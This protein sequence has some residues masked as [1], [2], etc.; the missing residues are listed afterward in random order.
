MHCISLTV[1]HIFLPRFGCCSDNETEAE[2]PDGLG[3]CK[4][5]E[6]GCCEDGETE[7][8]GPDG[9]GCPVEEEEMEDGEEDKDGGKL[10]YC[11]W[12][13]PN[14]FFLNYYSYNNYTMIITE[15]FFLSIFEI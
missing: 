14:S 6:F 13:I 7:A 12:R 1:W 9:E 8:Q 10:F 2:G 5:S 3:C 11:A 4:V 15:L